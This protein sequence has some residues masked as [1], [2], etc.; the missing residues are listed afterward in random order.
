MRTAC[1]RLEARLTPAPGHTWRLDLGRLPATIRERLPDNMRH[2]G[3]VVRLSFRSPTPLGIHYIGRNHPLT[4]AL[5]EEVLGAA[6][7][8]SKT[9]GFICARASV[10]HSSLV[11]QWTT[12][13]L[14]RLRYL[15]RKRGAAAP[16]LAEEIVTVGLRGRPGK[17]QL[18]PQNE[19]LRLLE[20]AR[21]E[22]PMAGNA[23]REALQRVLTW[24]KEDSLTSAFEEVIHQRRERIAEAHQRLR[25]AARISGMVQIDPKWPPDW[26]GVY[27]LLPFRGS[28][29]TTFR[30]RSSV[31]KI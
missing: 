18:L 25:Q 30:N 26:L 29:K 27:V 22:A 16:L 12:L 1:Q 5:A 14:L 24:W 2:Q 28:E 23:R 3:E 19:A 10:I 11:S 7:T 15:L 8:Q 13:F 6:L 31:K 21:P 17:G 9:D 4:E 20:E